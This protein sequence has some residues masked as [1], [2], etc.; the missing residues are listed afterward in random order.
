MSVPHRAGY[1]TAANSAV[2]PAILGSPAATESRNSW[3][4]CRAADD[5]RAVTASRASAR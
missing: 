1:G 2:A 5:L 4:Y 3:Q